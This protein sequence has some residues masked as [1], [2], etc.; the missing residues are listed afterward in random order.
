MQDD[1][2]FSKTPVSIGELRADKER[3]ASM[4]TPRECL[5][6]ALRDI[7]SGKIKPDV[8]FIGFSEPKGD[9]IYDTNYYTSA[10]DSRQ[11]IGLMSILLS[12]RIERLRS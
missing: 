5:I 6:A 2:D 10:K 4:W 7:D 8:L 11:C 1:T 3:R 12:D 9:D